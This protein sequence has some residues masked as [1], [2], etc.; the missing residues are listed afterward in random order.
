MEPR[1]CR[2]Q[3]QL[4]S[5]VVNLDLSAGVRRHLFVLTL[6][7]EREEIKKGRER[8]KERDRERG[9]AEGQDGWTGGAV[10]GW[11]MGYGEWGWGWEMEKWVFSICR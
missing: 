5:A 10:E 2:R 9:D 4:R 8:E 6:E 1:D 11:R 3:L 7:Q